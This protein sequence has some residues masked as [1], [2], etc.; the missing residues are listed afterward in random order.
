MTIATP[1]AQN[2]V[3]TSSNS[4]SSHL[5]PDA[6]ISKDASPSIAEAAPGSPLARAI[7]ESYGKEI[8]NSASDEFLDLA[9]GLRLQTISARELVKLLAKAKRLGY[10]ETDIIDDEDVR[11][12]QGA[13]AGSWSKAIGI[14]TPKPR[15]TIAS[16]CRALSTAPTQTPSLEEPRTPNRTNTAQVSREEP[17]SAN[18]SSEKA[19]GIRSI[20]GATGFQ[21]RVSTAARAAGKQG[22]REHS[23]TGS[24]A[25]VAAPVGKSS[26]VLKRTRTQDVGGGVQSRRPRK[27]VR[28]SA[29][30]SSPSISSQPLEVVVITDSEPESED[31]DDH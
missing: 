2:S 1:T 21:D 26:S 15:A 22:K 30:K 9:V 24:V 27:L 11:H 7:L 28:T 17:L 29:G 14:G 16:Q 12:V 3:D 19:G 23:K 25:R 6:I 31:D 13:N 8:L 18:A 10:Q 4:T 5:P 20:Q